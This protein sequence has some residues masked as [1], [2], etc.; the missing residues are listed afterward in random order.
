MWNKKHSNKNLNY[1]EPHKLDKDFLNSDSDSMS[2]QTE[3][4]SDCSES[5]DPK[6][7]LHKQDNNFFD[8]ESDPVTFVIAQ[9]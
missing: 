6:S 8:S 1:N 2:S 3:Y 5:N 4:D 9:L 7:T